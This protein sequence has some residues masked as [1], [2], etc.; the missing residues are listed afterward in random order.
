MQ[1]KIVT[2]GGTTSIGKM[3]LFVML[4]EKG[5]LDVEEIVRLVCNL[6]G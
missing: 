3:S 1:L 6:A 4:K 2:L 5:H